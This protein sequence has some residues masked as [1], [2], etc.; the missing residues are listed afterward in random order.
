M[1]V[2]NLGSI[3]IDLIYS[4]SNFPAPGETLAAEAFQQLP[5]GKGANQS[6]A[7]ALAGAKVFHIG[8]MHGG[9]DW[10]KRHLS[11]AGV[12][13]GFVQ[14]TETPGGHA[15]VV[16][17]AYG[18]NQIILFPGANHEIDMTRAC[19]ALEAA[20]ADDW[21]LIQNET[22]G[23]AEFVAAARRADMKIA[24]AAAPF[25]AEV[26]LALLP[27]VD[28]LMVNAIEAAALMQATGGDENSL[29]VDHLVITR[30][31]AGVSY[32]GIAGQ[33]SQPAFGV[34]VV[35]TTGAGDCFSGY[36]L[37]ALDE[38]RDVPE[39]LNLASAAAALQVTRHGA[40]TA[41]PTLDEVTKFLEDKTA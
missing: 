28:L 17:N 22:N 31:S 6:V 30:G 23:A 9:D 34:D 38:G 3:N 32:S 35:D 4:V 14:L 36:F 25:D 27:Q 2:F 19:A 40:A 20:T 39:A 12:D 26:T 15:I 24:Y 10:L 21:V 1:A 16:V 41:I 8:A 29:G 5:G 33:F 11:D 7:L 37:A 18:E 13:L